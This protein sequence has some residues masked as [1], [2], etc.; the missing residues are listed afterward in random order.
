MRTIAGDGWAT[1]NDRS[2]DR[3]SA[4]VQRSLDGRE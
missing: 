4:I 3:G 2:A 1:V